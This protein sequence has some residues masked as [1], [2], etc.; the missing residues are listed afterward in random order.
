MVSSSIYR[1]GISRFIQ[2]MAASLRFNR[3][4]PV[5]LFPLFSLQALGSVETYSL[6][7]QVM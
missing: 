6:I 3:V 2:A 4:R 5:P 1:S 7:R